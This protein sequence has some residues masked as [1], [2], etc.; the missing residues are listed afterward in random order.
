MCQ[1]VAGSRRAT[2]PLHKIPCMSGMQL[3]AGESSRLAALVGLRILDTAPD[4]SFDHVVRL[5]ASAFNAPVALVS[6]V[7]RDRQWFK[8]SVGLSITETSRDIAFC[9]H[10]IEHG[11]D[12]FVVNDA[13]DDARFAANPLVTGE[14]GIRFYAGQPV[15]APGGE[16]VG[17]VCVIDLVPRDLDARG[18]DLLAGFGLL[19]E[20]LLAVHAS[21]SIVDVEPPVIVDPQQALT[22]DARITEFMDIIC[23][24]VGVLDREH[25]VAAGIL[26]QLRGGQSLRSILDHVG[27]SDARV[28]LT[29]ALSRLEEG[30][31][32]AR[33]DLFRALNNQ[34]CSIGEIARLWGV[35]RQLV[36]R[37]LRDV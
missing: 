9:A 21:G 12:A 7:D 32:L 29:G 4:A 22:L 16:R 23:Q 11:D 13:L 1:Q 35:S 20:R 37:M 24:T 8:A 34:G 5:V 17:T 27:M 26:E 10:A 6:L 33:I 25:A 36:S 19:V 15:H 28:D 31:R 14:P 30:R 18:R 3:V 2:I